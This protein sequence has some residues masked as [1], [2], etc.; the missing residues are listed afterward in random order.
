MGN[1]VGS[2]D[3]TYEIVENWAKL[4]PGWSFKEIGAVG[5]DEGSRG[6]VKFQAPPPGRWSVEVRVRFA[7]DR[8]T[9]LYFWL[10]AVD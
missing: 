5:V 4:P 8:G 6:P 7:G 2:G 10:I 9:A 3:Y 1:V